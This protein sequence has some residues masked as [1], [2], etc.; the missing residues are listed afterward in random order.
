MLVKSFVAA[1]VG[2]LALSAPVRAQQ[3]ATD[4]DPVV[5]IVDGVAVH[6]SQ[7]EE[8]ARGLP[9]QFRQMP[10]Q[11]LFGVLLDRVV[12]FQLLANEAERQDLETDPAVQIALDRARANVLRDALIRR[13]IDQG[14]TDAKLHERYDQL[15][16]TAN[17][18]QPEVHARHILLKSE[19]EAKAVIKELQGGADF[20]T[21]AQQRSTGPSA[22]SGGDLG[23]FRRD[24]MVPQFAE[25]A[26]ALQPG[27]I[28]T[29]PV[30]TQFGWHVIM[31][32]DR[33]TVEPTF[34]DSEAQ[35]RQDVARD[36]VT[37]LVAGLHEGAKIE[38][39]NLDG[40]PMAEQPQAEQPQAKQPEPQPEAKPKAE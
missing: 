10:M 26:F 17:F 2:L 5:A 3:P 15:R 14:T 32:L 11:V 12:D 40:T 39:F 9:E 6:R 7:I 28:T 34:E 33:R 20:A 36:I 35:L 27:Q 23:F 30:Q 37:S 16:Q 29:E 13:Q 24:Q 22:Q 31:V 38:R 4:A 19:D 18:A 21:L 25:A 8:T 1:A